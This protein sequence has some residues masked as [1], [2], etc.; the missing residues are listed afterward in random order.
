VPSKVLVTPGSEALQGYP[1]TPA[2]LGFQGDPRQKGLFCN[3]SINGVTEPGTLTST[4]NPL[5]PVVQKRPPH[6]QAPRTTNTPKLNP[7]PSTRCD[8]IM[9]PNNFIQA[10]SNQRLLAYYISCIV[11]QVYT[12]ITCITLEHQKK[13]RDLLKCN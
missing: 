9:V 3:A 8:T 5:N 1:V 2:Y 13:Y 4:L 6:F 11:S 10:C 12:R 7:K